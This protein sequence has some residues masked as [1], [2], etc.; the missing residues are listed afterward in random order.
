MTIFLAILPFLC[1]WAADR[2]IKCETAAE[3]AGRRR[4]LEKWYQLKP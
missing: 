1:L 3:R 2:M 4:R